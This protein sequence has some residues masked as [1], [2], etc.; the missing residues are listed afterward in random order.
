MRPGADRASSPRRL[1]CD[2]LFQVRLRQLKVL[3]GPSLPPL[4]AM[5]SFYGCAAGGEVITVGMRG[6]GGGEVTVV[7]M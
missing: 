2:L 1:A 5:W 4:H 6:N 7:G 3:G